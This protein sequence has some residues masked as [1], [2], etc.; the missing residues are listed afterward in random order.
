MNIRD[1]Y[2]HMT[3]QELRAEV[4]SIVDRMDAPTVEQRI[5]AVRS[6]ALSEDDL[7]SLLRACRASEK[8]MTDD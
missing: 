7:R 1:Q 4:Y 5:A 6:A 3:H 2:H 8:E